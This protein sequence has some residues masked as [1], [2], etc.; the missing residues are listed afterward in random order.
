MPV[1]QIARVN[2]VWR[3]AP[4][5]S[6]VSYTFQYEAGGQEV[7]VQ[8]LAAAMREGPEALTN[9]VPEIF[10]VPEGVEAGTVVQTLF[11]TTDQLMWGA[12]TI[13]YGTV[14]DEML[15]DDLEAAGEALALAIVG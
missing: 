6:G 14:G 1:L 7:A 4:A 5:N 2:N 12:Q 15:I 11:G 10:Q 13:I 3:A 8:Q 9:G